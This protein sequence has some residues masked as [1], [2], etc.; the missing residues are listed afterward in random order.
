MVVWSL[1]GSLLEIKTASRIHERLNTAPGALRLPA[2]TVVIRWRKSV[3]DLKPF[4]T[5]VRLPCLM[6]ISRAREFRE[7]TPAN[8]SS[9]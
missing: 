3:A 9:R 2:A 8:R 1:D 5:L 4:L 6:C 7:N